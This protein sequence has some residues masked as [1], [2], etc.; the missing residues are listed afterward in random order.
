MRLKELMAIV[1]LAIAALAI[2]LHGQWADW[3]IE[4]LT[5]QQHDLVEIRAE[6]ALVDAKTL[7]VIVAVKLRETA[8][9]QE[10]EF[11]PVRGHFIDQNGT[12]YS[13][14]VTAV[15]GDLLPGVAPL[16]P[17]ETHILHRGET[18]RYAFGPA[19]TVGPTTDG[20]GPKIT[21]IT[22]HLDGFAPMG[23]RLEKWKGPY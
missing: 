11:V 23:V 10:L 17:R 6:R 7:H 14:Y 16:G 19:W 3:R 12:S 1:F 5:R 15:G 21:N 18:Y 4:R 20:A 8:S 2:L 13:P 22:L 9:V